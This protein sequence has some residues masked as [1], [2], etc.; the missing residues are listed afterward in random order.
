MMHF[1]RRPEIHLDCFTNRRDVIEYAPVVNAIEVIPEWWKSLPKSYVDPGDGF[2]PSGTMKTC[3]GMYNY[4]NKSIAMP[5]WSDLCIKVSPNKTYAWQFSDLL[6]TAVVHPSPQYSGFLE[7]SGYGHLKIE[8]PW[9]FNT[10][11]DVDWLMTAPV[12]NLNTFR[13]FTQA[14]GLLNF[15]RQLGT[16]IQLFVD[17]NTPRVYT[18]PF[19]TIFLFTP[20][21]DKKVVIHRHLI[22]DGEFASQ[23]RRAT[24][25]TFI[26]KYVTQAKIP[27]CPYKD[28]TK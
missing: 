20:M 26:N 18:I 13:D 17:T 23:G 7:G 9:N 6:T 16:N 3:V 25:I 15:H 28:K 10:K 5:L 14:Q 19:R 1:F 4:Y 11:S 21:T 24:A 22:S 2:S 12:Y 27:K 8:S